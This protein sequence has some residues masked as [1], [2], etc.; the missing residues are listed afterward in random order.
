[1]GEM[2]SWIF[3]Q[4][5]FKYTADTR[6]CLYDGSF[7]DR[8]YSLGLRHKVAKHIAFKCEPLEKVYTP[9]QLIEIAFKIM[10][11]HYKPFRY[12]TTFR[13]TPT[14]TGQW[15]PT[16]I[17]Y[18]NLNT[19]CSVGP[20]HNSSKLCYIRS[21][22][23]FSLQMTGD[24]TKLFYHVTSWD[25]C[26][27]ITNGYIELTDNYYPTYSDFQQSSAL[28]MYEDLNDALEL[29]HKLKRLYSSELAII[30]FALPS[31]PPSTLKFKHLQGDEWV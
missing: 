2:Q 4:E 21:L 11:D 12:K 10:T 16:E 5:W 14:I 1:M 22:K 30:I 23:K 17:P 6:G 28:Y 29:G 15:I 3:I 24:F 26:Q 19:D 31:I 13:Y 9:P 7:I 20:G 27:R 18:I 25:E 8:L